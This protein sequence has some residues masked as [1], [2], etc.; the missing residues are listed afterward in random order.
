[1][2]FG[3]TRR[4]ASA[5]CAAQKSSGKQKDYFGLLLLNKYGAYYVENAQQ[6]SSRIAPTL[7]L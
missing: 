6:F 3:F 1:V 4:R 5:L 7:I 2:A